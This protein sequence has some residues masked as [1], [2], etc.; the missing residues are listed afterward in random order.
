MRL[1]LLECPVEE[2]IGLGKVALDQGAIFCPARGV[3][4]KCL[5][6]RQKIISDGDLNTKR[7][8][9]YS[10]YRKVIHRINQQ[11]FKA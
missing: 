10:L 8:S 6:V 4:V 5:T 11:L 3:I 9:K 7:M 2:N 1:L